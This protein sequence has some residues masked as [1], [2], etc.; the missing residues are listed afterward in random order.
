MQFIMKVI[1]HIIE[2]TNI[3]MSLIAL[4]VGLLIVNFLNLDEEVAQSIK[5]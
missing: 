3:V 1:V 4:N 5:L 2:S